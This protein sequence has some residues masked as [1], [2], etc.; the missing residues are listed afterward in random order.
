MENANSSP[1]G[2]IIPPGG[3]GG[4]LHPGGGGGKPPIGGPGGGPWPGG[5][6]MPGGGGGILPGGGPPGACCWLSLVGG[7][8]KHIMV[9]FTRLHQNSADRQIDK[10]I[11]IM[12]INSIESS[13]R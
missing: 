6:G 13:N 9:Q 12:S 7:A 1:N 11:C 10:H 5:I 8:A 4:P 2:G 3:G